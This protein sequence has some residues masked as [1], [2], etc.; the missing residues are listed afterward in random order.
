M[1]GSKSGHAARPPH[2]AT[3]VQVRRETN[4]KN[5]P[6]SSTL[7]LSKVLDPNHYKISPDIPLNSPINDF[8]SPIIASIGTQCLESVPL[9]LDVTEIL[10]ESSDCLSKDYLSSLADEHEVD[11]VAA[12]SATNHQQV[13]VMS[14]PRHLTVGDLG[15]AFIANSQS[16]GSSTSD[17]SW[18][19]DTG[20]HFNTENW[21]CGTG[22]DNPGELEKT[23]FL[24]VVFLSLLANILAKNKT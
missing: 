24:V 7:D 20:A 4:G 5:N 3:F 2:N 18:V 16:A 11:G 17:T 23:E 6:W 13:N 1:K 21:T 8:N 19:P 12:L 9:S 14:R 22:L 10:R 15:R